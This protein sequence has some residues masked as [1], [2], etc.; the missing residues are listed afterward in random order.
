MIGWL[1]A[2]V[3][4]DA[5]EGSFR[6]GK[7]VVVAGLSGTGACSGPREPAPAASRVSEHFI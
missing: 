5:L 6:A 2:G 7:S 3:S 4:Y 1:G